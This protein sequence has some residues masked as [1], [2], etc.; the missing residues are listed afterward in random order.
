M[1]KSTGKFSGLLITSDFDS[2]FFERGFIARRNLD[3]VQYFMDNGGLFTLN[4]ARPVDS[5]AK[6]LPMFRINAP[7]VLG[8]GAVIYD[9]RKND[10]LDI[11]YMDGCAI[12]LARDIYERFSTAGIELYVDKGIYLAR[13][14]PV[15]DSAVQKH[16]PTGEP[17]D[18]YSF[19]ESLTRIVFLS[20]PEINSRIAA[21]VEQHYPGR[22]QQIRPFKKIYNLMAK[23]VTKGAG[24]LKLCKILG[25]ERQKAVAIG[26]SYNDTEMLKAAGLS[27]CPQNA[28]EDI[29]AICNLVVGNVMEGAVADLIEV[30]DHKNTEEQL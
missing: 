17:A 18:I 2:T 28:K 4:T 10:I 22:F 16:R 29:K 7:A 6:Y 5:I 13:L 1:I 11:T 30:L 25:I 8:N 21:Y 27:V 15:L 26:D 24:L 23:G 20:E 12:Q 19:E 14:N 3:A 9:Y